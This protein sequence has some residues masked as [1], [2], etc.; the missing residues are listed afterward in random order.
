MGAWNELVK[1]PVVNM[2][3]KIAEFIPYLLGAILILLI[4]WIVA[5]LLSGLVRK[6]LDSIKFNDISMKIG[7][8]DLLYKGGVTLSP[9]ALIGAVVYWALMIVTLAITVDAIGL[10]VA[11][12]LLERVSGYIPNVASAIFVMIVGMFLANL[13]SGVVRAT[14]AKADLPRVEFMAGIARAAIL[15]FTTVIV[16][17]EL[18][19]A[20]FFVTTTFQV[21]FAAVDRKSVV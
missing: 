11:A 18:N 14:A 13:V 9:S 19:I 1:I 8:S 7:L 10:K 5:N 21:F 16:L 15:V 6:G 3:N 20:S 2:L 17:E 4:G 12:Q